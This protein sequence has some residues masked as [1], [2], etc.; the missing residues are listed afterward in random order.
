M[1]SPVTSTKKNGAM[2]LLQRLRDCSIGY[3]T[4]G[5]NPLM[6][7]SIVYD[8][9]FTQHHPQYLY[10]GLDQGIGNDDRMTDRWASF[11][12][13]HGVTSLAASRD[14]L[15]EERAGR[16]SRQQRRRRI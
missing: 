14:L 4:N 16:T 3:P 13:E 8:F 5:I 10:I 2:A 7:S 9:L 6:K 15:L 12:L 11:Q 1:I